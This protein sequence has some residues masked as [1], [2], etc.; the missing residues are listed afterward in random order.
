M[1][2]LS[3]TNDMLLPHHAAKKPKVTWAST[4]LP[5]FLVLL[6]LPMQ[7]MSLLN[8]FNL[9]TNNHIWLGFKMTHTARTYNITFN[10][11]WRILSTTRSQPAQWNDKT[12][13]LFD[14]LLSNLHSG[15]KNRKQIIGL[16]HPQPLLNVEASTLSQPVPFFRMTTTT[17]M[18]QIVYRALL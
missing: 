6:D 18:Y 8:S 15:G 14:P 13:S 16:K 12:L 10:H 3:S 1:V 7:P 9:N 2:P 11:R 4:T 17:K 5:V